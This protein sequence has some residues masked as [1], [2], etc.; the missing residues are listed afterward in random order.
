MKVESG[1]LQGTVLGLLIF[2]LYI[3]IGISSSW[4]LFADD[5]VLYR[6][7]ESDQDQN[8]LQSDLNLIFMWSQSWKMWFNDNKCVTLRFHRSSQ[9]SSFTYFLD[10][11]PINCVTEHSYLYRCI[12]NIISVIFSSHHCCY[13]ASKMLNCT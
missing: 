2:L 10:S 4:R 6:I 7:F 3:N 5:C 11:I 12:V 1:V 9:P 8:C 13:K